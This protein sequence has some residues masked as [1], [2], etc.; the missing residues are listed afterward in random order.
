MLRHE[1]LNPVNTISMSLQN[2]QQKN[3]SADI[4]TASNAIKQLQVI[5]SSLTEAANI[6]EAL[7]QDEVEVIDIAALLVE[8]VS[9][10]QLKHVGAKLR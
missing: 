9:N 2:I 7:Q 10:S 6:D 5:V 1:I 4:T 3:D 8:Y